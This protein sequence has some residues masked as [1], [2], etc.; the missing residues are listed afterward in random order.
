MPRLKTV[1]MWALLLVGW[2]VAG[3][4]S[5]RQ[6]YEVNFPTEMLKRLDTFEAH[7][8]ANANKIFT[9]KSF[10]RA[11]AEYD[12]F[13]IE[14]PRSKAVPFALLRKARCLHL[15]NKRYDAIKEYQEVLD[16]F[17]DKIPF[18]AP[19]LYY[20]ALSHWENGNEEKALKGWAEMA[21]D[22]DYSKHRL[23]APGLLKLAEAMKKQE[24]FKQAVEYFDQVAV[25]FRGRV[26]YRLL[27]KAIDEVLAYHLR[28]KPDEA[29]LRD[30]YTR[31]KGFDWR[32]TIKVEAPL[33]SLTYWATARSLVKSRNT[34]DADKQAGERREYF[35]YWAKAIAGKFPDDDAHQ[36]DLALFQRYHEGDVKRWYQRVDRQYVRKLD[37]KNP[38]ARI[39]RWLRVYKGHS[40]KVR[41]YMARIKWDKLTA[42][43]IFELMIV[44]SDIEEKG[45]AKEAYAH[46]RF[47]QMTNL[48]IIELMK[49]LFDRVRD[50]AMAKNLFGRINLDDMSDQAK[51]SLASY[52]WHRSEEL[53]MRVY[54]SL[55]DEDL[56][57]A[58]RMRYFRWRRRPD[59]G[60][61]W[62]NKL[63]VS[64]DYAQEAW[65]TMAE[66]YEMK[67]TWDKAVNAYIQ[68]D[69]PPASLWRVV[70]C[71]IHWRK[72]DQAIGQLKEIENFFEAYKARA[73]LRMADV[74]RIAGRREAQ[75]AALRHV[76]KKYVKS[77]E[78][79]SAHQQLEA[80]GVK[81]GG[82][83]DAD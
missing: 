42:K 8:L 22:V 18:A 46:L 20:Q 28:R 9:T 62:A 33:T 67:K 31:V 78:S 43:G 24:R 39:L 63:T 49:I 73:A 52:L 69:R 71:Y 4:L 17:P 51:Y 15:D 41:E 26:D 6:E 19:A 80:L 37:A 56:G 64:P 66:F 53:V 36:L 12:S 60:L 27:G 7:S 47:D 5:A 45:L 30:F 72:Y 35:K 61:P 48:Q 74:Y 54:A 83:T 2:G 29:K 1:R 16:Y 11:G 21:E 76:M 55:D 79:T 81:M 38:N 10:R 77:G 68:S 50:A 65:W 58:G 13:I 32:R 3:E 14:F 75:I 23:A 57:S 82:G 40:K 70:D 44:L 59:E 25:N 34:F